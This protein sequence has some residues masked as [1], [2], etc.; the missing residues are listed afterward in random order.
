MARIARS[1]GRHLFGLDPVSY[2]VGRP[3]HPDRVY[4]TLRERCGLAPGACVLEVGPGTGQATRVLLEL[5]S[6][7][8]VV[9]EPNEALA[10]HLEATLGDRIDVARTTL[11]EADLP[12]G[13]FDLATAASSFHWVD[14][15]T[16]LGVIRHALRPGGWIALWW[17]LFGEGSEPDD[18]I[19]ATRPL[20]EGLD[21][22]PTKGE[23]GRPAH[24]LDRESRTTALDAAR[25][26]EIQTEVVQ[27]EVD[28][29]AAGIRALYG[30]FSPILRLEASRRREILGE[31]ERIAEEDFGGRV[32]RTLT[33]SL[34]SARKPP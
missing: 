34:Y 26:V 33:T 9:V 28:W 1:E 30:T 5:G 21:S 25:F 23:G 19:R 17:T 4:E 7:P 16:G 2:E 3:G 32:S 20:L 11:E 15:P 10:D 29:D 27:W 13:S 14:E 12:V 31:I 8:L 6:S 18:F 24:G 22:S